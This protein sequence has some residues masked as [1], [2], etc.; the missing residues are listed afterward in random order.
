MIGLKNMITLDQIFWIVFSVIILSAV[1]FD[2][3]FQAKRKKALSLKEAGLWTL[4]WIG[5]AL[6]FNLAIYFFLGHAKALEF[7]TAYLL[8][9]SLSLD[10]LFV[11]LAIFSYFGLPVLSQQKVL[12][13]GILGAFLMRAAFIFGGIWLLQRFDFLFYVFGAFLV[14]SGV[15]MLFSKKEKI[16][17]QKNWLFRI[18]KKI[19]P[20]AEDYNQ[21][22][23]FTKQNGIFCLTPLFIVLILIESSDL[24]FAIDSVPAV[25]AITQDSFIAYTSNAFAILGLRALYFFLITLL[26]KFIYL[27]KAVV[28]LLIFI[29]AK[30]ILGQ[31][32]HIPMVISLGFILMTLLVSVL[33]SLRKLKQKV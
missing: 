28:A 30:M 18:T 4:G 24:I 29:G 3:H 16:D 15:K 32:W 19:I 13:W 20:L 6:L 10:N 25:L 23:F 12:K 17:P 22:K 2:L 8:E 21:D 11:F 1:A 5:L 31:F 9:K 14:F 33:L 26:P 27:E 7:L